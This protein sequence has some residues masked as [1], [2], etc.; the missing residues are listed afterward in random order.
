MRKSYMWFIALVLVAVLVLAAWY[1]HSGTNRGLTAKTA[2]AVG[3]SDDV[4]Y[5]VASAPK[6]GDLLLD[7]YNKPYFEVVTATYV[8]F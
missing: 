3:R 6:P 8:P 1:L 2:V 7:R 5:E 4:A